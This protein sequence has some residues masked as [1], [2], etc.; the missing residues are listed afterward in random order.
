MGLMDII[1]GG[2]NKD[3]S[4]AMDKAL[5]AIGNVQTPTV[6]DLTYEIQ[7]LVQTGQITPEQAKTFL[8][9]PSAFLNQ[10]INQKGKEAQETSIDQLLGA[11]SEGGIN[12]AEEAKI[13]DIIRS[14][15][16]AEKGAND[17]VIQ[18]QAERGAL[19]GGETLAAQLKNNQDAA[20]NANANG[21]NTAAEGY[22]AML[23][24]L[25]S[26]GQMGG[27]LQGQQNAQANTVAAATDAINKFNAAQ[28]QQQENFNV[29]NKNEAQAANTNTGQAIEA[30]NVG[31]ANTH[32]KDMSQ[33][34][35][36]VYEDQMQKATGVA[37]ANANKAS[38][39]T[40]Q[41]GQ[42]AGLIGGIIGSGAEA[43]T[44]FATKK[45]P[46][47]TAAHGGEI[48]SYL[49]GGKVGGRAVVPGDSPKNDRIPA[50]LSP[51]EVVLPRSVAHSEP[52]KV[53]EFLNRMRKPKT[54]HPEDVATMLHAMGSMRE[55]V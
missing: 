32:A 11:A 8:A 50:I 18:R 35:Q 7:K 34:P 14:L 48:E 26:A 38:L 49:S 9:N 27:Q 54:P 52:D 29:A 22:N 51:G 33:L 45:P 53:M 1:T 42:E 39:D 43:A 19:T 28:Q 37:G 55:A 44:G 5:Q 20:V 46:V 3:A 24:E 40:T 23:N 16:T 2:K 6:A 30:A 47:A 4:A 25:T 17:A 13:S 10:N 15:G 12:P 21:M 36:Q 41:G 31:N